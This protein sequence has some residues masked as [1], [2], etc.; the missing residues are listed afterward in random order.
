MKTAVTQTNEPIIA[1]ADAPKTAICPACSGSVQLRKR[2][3]MGGGITY[4]WRHNNNNN[5]HSQCQ[6]RSTRFR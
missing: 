2:R 3:L 5:R 4:F 6:N 1:S